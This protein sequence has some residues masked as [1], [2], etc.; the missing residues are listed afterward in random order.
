[1]ARFMNRD[2]TVKFIVVAAVTVALIGVSALRSRYGTEV[3]RAYDEARGSLFLVEEREDDNPA[4][5]ALAI[6]DEDGQE[7]R[8]RGRIE[9][10]A[11]P[12][13]VVPTP[14]GVSVFVGW[15]DRSTI[16]VYDVETLELQED[17]DLRIENPTDVSFSPMGDRVYVTGDG[18][19]RVHVFRHEQLA[20]ERTADFAVSPDPR[21]VVPNH[22]ATS[23]FRPVDAG[24]EVLFAQTGE[25][26]DK[27]SVNGAYWTYEERNRHLWGVASRPNDPEAGDGGARTADTAGDG[28]E[29]P[30]HAD[31]AAGDA[32][33]DGGPAGESAW[34]RGVPAAISERNGSATLFEE[35]AVASQRPAID[36]A[37]WYLDVDGEKLHGFDAEPAGGR[38]ATVDLESAAHFVVSAGPGEL[39]AVSTDGTVATV[40]EEGVHSEF[41]IEAQSITHA[42]ASVIQEDGDFA[43]F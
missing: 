42:V 23:L 25:V 17:I 13:F 38:V 33:G 28:G 43:C 6:G 32:A 27:V 7:N 37:V 34:S 35:I 5:I 22:R 15:A 21:A 16:E 1:M 41:E 19:E 9:L 4:L 8:V 31:H 29:A 3:W 20:L 12:S 2:Q 11:V 40:R 39:W 30:G 18:G 36:L 24:V 14:G 10:D 26:T